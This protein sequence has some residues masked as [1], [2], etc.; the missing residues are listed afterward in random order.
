MI[1]FKAE[2]AYYENLVIK[3][4]IEN[5]YYKKISDVTKE[6]LLKQVYSIIAKYLEEPV[7]LVQEQYEELEE[8]WTGA[9]DY[10]LIISP[11]VFGQSVSVSFEKL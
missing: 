10:Y 7:I 5:S 2:D 1:N 8:F 3:Y 4:N 11:Y 9:G 6:I